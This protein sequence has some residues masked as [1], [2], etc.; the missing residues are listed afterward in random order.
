[1][2]LISENVLPLTTLLELGINELQQFRSKVSS[3]DRYALEIL[4]R[5]LIEQTD[6][7]WS[8]FQRCFSEPIR[9]WIRSHP[10]CDVALLRD[11]EENYLAQTFSRFWY[12]VHH[13]R[14]EFTT[15]PAA[16]SYMHATLNGVITDTL[17]YHLR[18]CSREIPIPETGLSNEPTTDD[19]LES[20][21]VWENI[22]SLLLDE[23]ERRVFYLLYYC[24]LKPR[25]IVLRCPREF[26]EVKEIYRLNH[27]IIERLRRNSEWVRY[28][29]GK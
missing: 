12:A 5:A 24:G 15:L 18:V 19:S 25:E 20:E 14:I 28:L 23:R 6:E 13:Q 26:A 4:H 22:Q 11:S 17:R 7:A 29:C 10:N 1:M 3:D 8:D 2:V 16:L 21:G 9:V 27:N